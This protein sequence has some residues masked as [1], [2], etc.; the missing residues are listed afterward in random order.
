MKVREIQPGE[1]I[2]G[3]YQIKSVVGKGAFSVVYKA[4]DPEENTNCAIKVYYPVEEHLF[5]EKADVVFEILLK[6]EHENICR[7]YEWF[8]EGEA[9]YS[10]TEYI[11][12]SNLR[13]LI[14]M[15]KEEK[16]PFTLEETE[17]II[18]GVLNAL[19]YAGHF[20]PHSYLKPEHIFI[21]PQKI[22]VTDFG[23]PYIY[24]HE[25][26][27]AKL[28][29]EGDP[30]YYIP[31]E[32]VSKKGKVTRAGDVYSIGVIL[33]E[34]LTGVMP[35]KE[36]PPPSALNPKI[37]KDVDSF[38]MKALSPSPENRFRD[39]QEFKEEFFY[40]LDKP[41]RRETTY[42]DEFLLFELLEEKEEKIERLFEV[43]EAPP[44]PPAVEEKKIEKPSPPPRAEIRPVEKVEKRRT[45]LWPFLAILFL[46][47]AGAGGYFYMMEKKGEKKALAPS[48]PVIV[49][50]EVP[51]KKI[52]PEEKGQEKKE[53]VE[54]PPPE[55]TRKEA[56]SD[57]TGKPEREPTEALASLPEKKK[58]PPSQRKK[59]EKPTAQ[60]PAEKPPEKCPK[61]ML[62]IPAGE[63][64]M[65]SASDDPLRDI[66]DKKLQKVFVDEFCIDIY[67]YPNQK[68]KKPMVNVTYYE[69][70]AECEKIGKR[71]CSEEEWEKAC[72]GIRMTRYPYGNNW[73]P[74]AC[75][76]ENM[77]GVDR[78]LQ[79]SGSFPACK[80]DYEIYDMSGNAQEWTSTLFMK[81][82]N[83]MVLKGGSYTSPDYAGRCAYRYSLPPDERA[84]ENGFR[85]CK[86][87]RK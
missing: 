77:S 11:E 8:R 19:I 84:P 9:Y 14:N 33:Y 22:L 76:T 16:K 83:D 61:G 40:L 27:L 82:L 12:G 85:C 38:I 62:Y 67:E 31:P 26:F 20:L 4:W 23:I 15:R 81:G 68:G 80:S 24:G 34:M 13:K 53:E 5:H 7:T 44:S 37:D 47:G 21:L 29:M 49:K 75:V 56:E 55:E 64:L 10:K 60:L 73:D 42:T 86:D 25:V 35:R 65:G 30:Y 46:L 43:E 36:F 71:L 18:E 45:S 66:G 51:E 50:L 48:P 87:V 59:E 39:V 57:K 2:K 54:K 74:N 58:E 69:A 70:K 79:P 52:I 6:L 3:R 17:P 1:R 32:F 63:F 72:K 41:Y 28:V 78:S